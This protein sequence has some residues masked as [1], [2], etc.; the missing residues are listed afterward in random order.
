[1]PSFS[2]T[3]IR[4]LKDAT[5][6]K[7]NQKSTK[8]FLMDN[9]AHDEKCIKKY[10]R[11]W[12]LHSTSFSIVCNSCFSSVRRLRVR[13]YIVCT[14]RRSMDNK[15]DLM[16]LSAI[17]LSCEVA[18]KVGIFEVLITISSKITVLMDVT[19][20]L[21]KLTN[22]IISLRNQQQEWDKACDLL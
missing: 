5:K 8:R 22:Q 12:Y 9:V 6:H 13:T 3:I 4:I 15:S 20:I 11:K 18:N 10:E 1:M 16:A 7:A 17:S 19:V 2:V 14:K 21:I